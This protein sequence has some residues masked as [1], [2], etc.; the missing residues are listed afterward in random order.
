MGPL[1]A[2]PPATY[3]KS[4][5]KNHAMKHIHLLHVGLT[6]VRF[7]LELRRFGSALIWIGEPER[8]W[9]AAKTCSRIK[10]SFD[11]HAPAQ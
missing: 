1:E 6:R 3:W 7:G 4:R 9:T 2:P 8:A 5:K 11:A 10:Q